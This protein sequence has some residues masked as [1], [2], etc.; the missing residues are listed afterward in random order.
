MPLLEGRTFSFIVLLHNSRPVRG[1][2]VLQG[3]T[4]LNCYYNSRPPRGGEP[5]G[6]KCFKTMYNLQLTPPTLRGENEKHIQKDELKLTPRVGANVGQN[7]LRT[8]FRA[9]NSRPVLGANNL[10]WL[11]PIYADSFNS[12]P[13]G[14]EQLA[15]R[16]HCSQKN[17]NPRPHVGANPITQRKEKR[18]PTSTHAP[19]GGEPRRYDGT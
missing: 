9:F 19:C 4:D 11:Q 10:L 18:N 5:K 12:R 13:C 15:F 1:R 17:F 16:F 3:H 6:F 14:G 8:G 7:V 2:T